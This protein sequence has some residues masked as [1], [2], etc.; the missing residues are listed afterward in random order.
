M[1]QDKSPFPDFEHFVY[2]I[3][4]QPTASKL[5]AWSKLQEAERRLATYKWAEA[6]NDP[7]T[8]QNRVLLNDAVS[9]FLLTFEATLQFAKNQFAITPGTPDFDA[10]L[11]AQ[12]ENDVLLRGLRTLRHFEAHVESKP[13]PRLVR[14]SIGGS[15]PDGTSKT[16]ASTDWKLP[17]LQPAGLTKLHHAP[18]KSADVKDWNNLVE[19]MDAPAIFEQGLIKLRKILQKAETVV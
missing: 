18:L 12:P 14:L 2:K 8:P 1:A 17:T 13:P 16:E 9:A 11:A 6:K 7:R 5:N 15:L 19:S 4:T 3:A 10:W